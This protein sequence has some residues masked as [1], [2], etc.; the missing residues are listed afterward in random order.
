MKFVHEII[1]FQN[2]ETKDNG[3]WELDGDYLYNVCGGRHVF[4]S[5]ELAEI[6]EAES[7]PDFYEKHAS[8]IFLKPNSPYGWLSPSG[9]FFGCSHTGHQDLATYFF[10]SS[11]RE[12]EDNGYIKISAEPFGCNLQ[13]YYSKDFISENQKIWLEKNGFV[14]EDLGVWFKREKEK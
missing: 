2:G 10:K 7:W 1:T 6:I 13:T 12:L 3:W 8:K 4:C 11:E 14:E 5:D 9:E